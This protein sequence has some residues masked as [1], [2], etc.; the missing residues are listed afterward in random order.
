MW[1]LWF[2]IHNLRALL[3]LSSQ[4]TQSPAVRWSSCLM[5]VMAKMKEIV[6]EYLRPFIR[7]KGPRRLLA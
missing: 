5:S 3:P 4:A 2:E 7:S 6:W 1:P